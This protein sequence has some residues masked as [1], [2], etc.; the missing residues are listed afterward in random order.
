MSKP[1]IKNSSTPSSDWGRTLTIIFCFMAMAAILLFLFHQNTN[2][3]KGATTLETAGEHRTLFE[4]KLPGVA[5]VESM[6]VGATE[7][8]KT[9]GDPV[10]I[11]GTNIR[12]I[13][14]MKNDVS[15]PALIFDPGISDEKIKTATSVKTIHY[16]H[17][18]GQTF[19]FLIE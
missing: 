6:Q 16:K 15:Y 2:N 19:F 18:G 8:I 13:N 11:P 17:R 14:V 1:D 9:V 3:Q 7:N 10:A 5:G 12:M 4:G